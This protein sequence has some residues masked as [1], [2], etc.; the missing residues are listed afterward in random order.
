MKE[1]L[2]P[3][4]SLSAI[5]KLKP[6]QAV[7]FTL[8]TKFKKLA[9][10]DQRITFTEIL[11]T[12]GTRETINL[13]SAGNLDSKPAFK[14]LAIWVIRNTWSEQLAREHTLNEVLTNVENGARVDTLYGGPST[15]LFAVI[16]T[17]CHQDNAGYA[18]ELII[19]QAL[20][21]SK[22]KESSLLDELRK[23]MFL[24]FAGCDHITNPARNPPIGPAL[25]ILAVELAKAQLGA[26]ITNAQLDFLNSCKAYAEGKI[27]EEDLVLAEQVFRRY[28]TGSDAALAC[29]WRG[30][31][32][33]I[34]RVLHLL[35]NE[36]CKE[37]S[38]K[39][40]KLKRIVEETVR[41]LGEIS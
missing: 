22:H 11:E 19:L 25:R 30:E 10:D 14:R 2:I 34:P 37:D 6:D 35:T 17:L 7:W 23:Q 39:Y 27:S 40:L 41:K 29:A 26:D 38:D 13:L 15:P 4:T 36:P 32:H 1:I 16:R 20:E 31:E 3:A 33:I 24:V 12:L 21:V 18:L 8:L 5:V 28:T 9:P